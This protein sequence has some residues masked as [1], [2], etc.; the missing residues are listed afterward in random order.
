MITDHLVV[1]QIII[2]L[3]AA[4]LCVFIRN[5]NVTW[6]LATIISWICLVIS[7]T[8]MQ[9]VMATGE[10]I[11]ELGGSPLGDRVPR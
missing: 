1:L 3:M 7:I 8:L 4:P 6:A 2:P 11:Y 5:A 9:Q 10:I